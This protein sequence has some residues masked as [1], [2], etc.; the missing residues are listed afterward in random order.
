MIRTVKKLLHRNKKKIN[1]ELFFKTQ[2]I[3]NFWAEKL[4]KNKDKNNIFISMNSDGKVAFLNLNKYLKNAK[5]GAKLN[6][7]NFIETLDSKE[8]KQFLIKNKIVSSNFL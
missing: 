6:L 4:V 5:S 3:L 2:K 1:L 8:F 7:N